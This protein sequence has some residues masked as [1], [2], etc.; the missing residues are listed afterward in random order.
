MNY[1][2]TRIETTKDKLVSW[3]I[4]PIG[5]HY[6]TNLILKDNDLRDLLIQ[7]ID[8]DKNL[9]DYLYHLIQK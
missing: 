8:Q 4:N 3:R 7:I 5:D 6:T 9:T 1:I 2:I